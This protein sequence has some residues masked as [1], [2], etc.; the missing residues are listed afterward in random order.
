MERRVDEGGL[1]VSQSGLE[2]REPVWTHS[3][4]PDP[5]HGDDREKGGVPIRRVCGLL[6]VTFGLAF[7]LFVVTILAGIGGGVGIMSGVGHA[8]K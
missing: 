6:P 5:Y 4:S 2:V 8:K 1:E 3:L 7:A